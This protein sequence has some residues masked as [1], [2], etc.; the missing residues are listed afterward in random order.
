MQYIIQGPRISRMGCHSK[1][2]DCYDLILNCTILVVN[3]KG[4]FVV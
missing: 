1:K 4:I 3:I 2:V